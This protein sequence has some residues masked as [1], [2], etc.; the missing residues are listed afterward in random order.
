MTTMKVHKLIINSIFILS[1]ILIIWINFI[2]NFY[3]ETFIK[4]D[5]IKLNR[6]IETIAVSYLTSFIF[7]F[8]IVI[9]KEKRDKKIL[10][11]FIADY[12]YIAMNN[13]MYFCFS[14]RNSAGLESVA[15]ETSIHDRNLNIY[16]NLEDLRAI[17]SKINPNE[18]KNED[19]GINGLQ[20]IPHFFGAMIHYTYRI[21][22]FLKIVLDKSNFIDIELLRILTDIQTHGYHQHML[23]YDKKLVMTAKH[24]HDNLNI[25]EKSLLS[26]FDLF[27]KLEDYS[28]R[29]LKN[30]VERKSLKKK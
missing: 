14:M 28:E 27:R 20:T 18:D 10:L 15:M 2:E 30:Y 29:N 12:V 1:I 7:Y 23:S 11:P 8:F 26:Y 24:R 13:C 16:P 5:Y 6:L 4:I 19:I 9:I 17:C 25:F 21:D 3:F 22:Y